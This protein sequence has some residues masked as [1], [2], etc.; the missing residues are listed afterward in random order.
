MT[1]LLPALARR[2]AVRGQQATRCIAFPTV[3]SIATTRPT[4]NQ[5]AK[6]KQQSKISSMDR[7]NTVLVTPFT[8]M[9]LIAMFKFTPSTVPERVSP[10]TISNAFM[11]LK[12]IVATAASIASLGV[13][14][15]AISAARDAR[16]GGDECIYNT[17]SAKRLQEQKR[18]WQRQYM[19]YKDSQEGSGKK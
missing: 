11:R 4:M 8:R 10:G 5:I 7:V 12:L 9:L 6:Y 14:E 19:E 18:E 15:I 2:L 3:R 13:A 17:P 16:D 1:P